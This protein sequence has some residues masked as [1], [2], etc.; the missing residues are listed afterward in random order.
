VS[1]HDWPGIAVRDEEGVVHWL[2][3]YTF[4]DGAYARNVQDRDRCLRYLADGAGNRFLPHCDWRHG[5]T[6]PAQ[7]ATIHHSDV[8]CLACLALSNTDPKDQ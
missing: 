5:H 3:W 2:P 7:E 8:T 6:Y 4:D 1:P